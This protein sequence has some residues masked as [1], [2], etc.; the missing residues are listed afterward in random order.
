[1]RVTESVWV[2]GCV[3]VWLFKCYYVACVRGGE[4]G[5]ERENVRERER[6]FTAMVNILI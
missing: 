5:T 3:R 4:G 2:R 1:M 6:P